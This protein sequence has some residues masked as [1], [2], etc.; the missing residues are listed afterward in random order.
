MVDVGGR[1]ISDVV[2]GTVVEGAGF[3]GLRVVLRSVVVVA[4]IGGVVG[5]VS[6]VVVDVVVVIVGV[7]VVIVVAV[8]EGVVVVL[9]LHGIC[10]NHALNPLQDMLLSVTNKRSSY[11][12]FKKVNHAEN[13]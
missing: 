4:I 7:R 1:V 3:V 8:V 13:I 2:V 11:V 9:Y 5:I 10:S 12:P 6:S